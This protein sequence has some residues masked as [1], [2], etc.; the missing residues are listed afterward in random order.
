MA[1]GFEMTSYPAPPPRDRTP[2]TR[3]ALSGTSGVRQK[4][5]CARI[6]R[7]ASYLSKPHSQA[8]GFNRFLAME[9]AGASGSPIGGHRQFLAERSLQAGF[10][11]SSK[12]WKH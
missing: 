8:A 12:V 4:A 11:G 5:G 10:P 2:Q 7:L 6:H 1:E 3:Q 9:L